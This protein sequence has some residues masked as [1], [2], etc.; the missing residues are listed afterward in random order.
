MAEG[1]VFHRD[2][3]TRRFSRPRSSR[4]LDCH[5]RR[6]FFTGGEVPAAFPDYGDGAHDAE[7]YGCGDKRLASAGEPMAG[8]CVKP[9]RRHMGERG[10]ESEVADAN[11]LEDSIEGAAGARSHQAASP[12]RLEH[13][14][15]AKAS[16]SRARGEATEKIRQRAAHEKEHGNPERDQAADGKKCEEEIFD[17][18]VAEDVEL[19][20]ERRSHVARASEVAVNA[21][22]SDGGDGQEDGHRIGCERPLRKREERD[23]CERCDDA[24]CGHLVWRHDKLPTTDV[25]GPQTP[26]ANF[27]AVPGS[28]ERARG[29]IKACG[30]P[31]GNLRSRQSFHLFTAMR[32][33]RRHR[34][35]VSIHSTW[36][37]LTCL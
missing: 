3:R 16:A 2:R 20:A 24:R 6:C 33:K 35:K 14:V 29:D 17:H 11:A 37:N 23:R 9:G 13:G 36:R 26:A 18:A 34:A 30:G 5:S 21:V 7:N 12:P 22:E 1:S 32:R 27:S 15:A 28:S 4:H 10:E 31:T 8:H 25:T 19:R